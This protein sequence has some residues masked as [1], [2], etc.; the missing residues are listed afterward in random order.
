MA[1]LQTPL[2]TE[3]G[4][5]HPV[6]QAP[7][8]SVST[9][10]LA[11]AVADAGGLG[12]LA[13]S[14]RGTDAIRDAYTEAASATSGVVGVNVVLDESTGVLSPSD[15]LDVCLDAGASAVSFSFGDAGS[16]VDRVNEAGGTAMVTVGS[17]D[18]ARAAVAAG[19][20]II[21]A[22]GREAGGHVQSDV[23]TMALLPRVAD[24][25][26]VPVVAAGGLGDGR[27]LAAALTLGADGGWFGTRFVATEQSG[28][29]EKYRRQIVDA[30]ET[31]TRLTDMF[32][33]GWLDQP[34][35]VLETDEVRQQG[36]ADSG[37]ATEASNPEQIAQMPDGE[38]ISRLA[39]MPPLAGMTG[40]VEALPHYAGQSAGLTQGVQPAGEVVT[41]L[42]ADARAALADASAAAE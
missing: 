33:R 18:E 42:V 3:I 27:G 10:A 17:A 39:D 8:G 31:A 11:A 7:V 19:A 32:D 23:T 20:D 21:V 15:C 22:Q 41:R 25:V 14:W 12:M 24:A 4:I 9:P 35:R 1:P 26:E 40:E 34:H 13:M 5:D 36:A 16:Y 29:H 2:C 28:A 30:P 37:V 38:P 6:V